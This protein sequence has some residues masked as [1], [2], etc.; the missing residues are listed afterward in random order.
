MSMEENG[1]KYDIIVV[2]LQPWDVALGSN[3]VDIAKVFSKTNRVLY[4]NR[5]TDRRSELKRWFSGTPSKVLDAKRKGYKL[6]Q[7]QSNLWVLDTG[8]V[9]DSIN[10][11]KGNLFKFLLRKNCKKLAASI[12]QAI[13]DLGFSDYLLFNDNDFFQGQFLK[14]EL[15]PQ[16]YI[17]YLRDYLINQPY[18]KRNGSKMEREL[19]KKADLVF[20][21]SNYLQRYAAAYNSYSFYIGQGCNLNSTSAVELSDTPKELFDIKRPI[22][23]YV[24]NLV[25]LRLDLSLLE[26]MA[27]S[28]QELSW[29]FVGPMD[30]GFAKSNIKKLSNVIFTGHKS[31]ADLPRYISCF[32][33][34]INP[35]LLNETTIGNYPR[36]IDEYMLLGKPVVARKTEFTQELGDVIYQYENED[37]FL[38][39]LD[40]AISENAA[41]CKI[42][43]RKMIASSHTWENSVKKL[44]E[45]I[46]SFKKSK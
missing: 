18:F 20:T 19:L 40:Y 2:G 25:T 5:P 45:T 28:R 6:S 17:Y 30:D 35:Q 33:V 21:N 26:K 46:E 32:D 39:S 14:E 10:L 9:L 13:A 7:V 38:Q 23:G 22:V 42:E 3:C 1:F 34:C 36:K 44:I 31:Q 37:E 29:V 8:L 27:S 11:F 24:G 43:E 4:V 15:S 16:L 41:S 12:K